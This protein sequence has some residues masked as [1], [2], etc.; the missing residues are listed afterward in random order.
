M[1]AL[2]SPQIRNPLEQR[3]E[4]YRKVSGLVRSKIPVEISLDKGPAGFDGGIPMENEEI[5]A[6]GGCP[7]YIANQ[8]ITFVRPSS[9][10]TAS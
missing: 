9:N 6:Y 4:F 10:D 2:M 1:N 5:L 7:E 8:Q 3:L